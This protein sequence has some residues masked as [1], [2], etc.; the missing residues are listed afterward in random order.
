MGVDMTAFELKQRYKR[1]AQNI[2]VALGSRFTEDELLDV[3]RC[4]GGAVCEKCGLDMYSHPHL[5]NGLTVTC[6]GKLVKL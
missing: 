6:E 2:A 3:D 1:M 5:K 4:G